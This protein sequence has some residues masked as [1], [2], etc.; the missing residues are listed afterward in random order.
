[1]VFQKSEK[2]AEG[3]QRTE[4]TTQHGNLGHTSPWLH[5]SFKSKYLRCFYRQPQ[6]NCLHNKSLSMGAH[7]NILNCCLEQDCVSRQMCAP[8]YPFGLRDIANKVLAQKL[9]RF[10][11]VCQGICII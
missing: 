11:Y 1:M 9:R 2:S 3:T 6:G 7:R 10:R 5:H 4:P 8:D